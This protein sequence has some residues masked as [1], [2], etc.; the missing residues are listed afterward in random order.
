MSLKPARSLVRALVDSLGFVILRKAELDEKRRKKI[1]DVH[2]DQNFMRAYEKAKR[3]TMTTLER[4]YALYKAIEFIVASGV[5]GDV[6][7]C[8]VWKGGSAMMCALALM[9]FGEDKKSI[10]LYDTYRG[11]TE[12]TEVD[13]DWSG[14]SAHAR[15]NE[16]QRGEDL[17]EWDLAPLEEAKANMYST[18]YPL[19]RLVFVEG[20]VEDTLPGT[21]P[22]RI[23]LL[24]LDT[25][26]YEST[27]HELAHLFPRL[28]R[29][30]VI[31]IDDYGFWE[32]QKRAVDQY[33]AEQR[34]KI[35]LNRVDYGTRIG[36]K[37]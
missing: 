20:K 27:Y 2:K 30:G 19:E 36:T 35:L 3:Y 21:A 15:W 34:I 33:L 13:R 32:G 11:M 26:W 17:N 18:G 5:D 22:E 16:L 25:D 29:S 8:G 7:E 28:S 9:E 24:R 1:S 4:M 37:V 23:S 12:P 14:E 6:V 10:Y 31:I